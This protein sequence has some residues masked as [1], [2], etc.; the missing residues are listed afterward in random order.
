MKLSRVMASK[1][2]SATFLCM[3]SF[4]FNAG[5]ASK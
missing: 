1:F 2:W 5:S 3:L 4:Y